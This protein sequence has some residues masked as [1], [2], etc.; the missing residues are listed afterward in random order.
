MRLI[1]FEQ[2]L[3]DYPIY[4]LPIDMKFLF[5]GEKAF[6]ELIANFMT[7]FIHKNQESDA[8]KEAI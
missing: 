1:K 6:T 2:A 3:I 8:G 4:V 7:T 5:N